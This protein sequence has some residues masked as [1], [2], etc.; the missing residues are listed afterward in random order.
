MDGIIIRQPIP[1]L[2]PSAFKST[3]VQAKVS[4]RS[5]N[6]GSVPASHT[7]LV[8]APE[9]PVHQQGVW[10]SPPPDPGGLAKE[11]SESSWLPLS[12]R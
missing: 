6:G 9:K 12:I 7:L 8:P 1:P 5:D 10:T 11:G 3:A 2:R 4:A